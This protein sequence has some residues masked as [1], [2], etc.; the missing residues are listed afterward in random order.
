MTQTD[1]PQL[2]PPQITYFN[3]V[4]HSLGNDPNVTVLNLIEFPQGAGYLISIIVDNRKKARAL[5]TILD[6]QK[7]IGNIVINLIVIYDK[8]I[9][10]PHSRSFTA[11]G[12]VDLFEDALGTNR[13]FKFAEAKP[14]SPGVT[15]VYPVFTKSVIQFFN[16][17]ISDIYGNFNEVTAF[18][19]R[20]VVREEINGILINPS[21]EMDPSTEDQESK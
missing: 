10:R 20:D 1:L 8:T 13:F 9:V 18:V 6:Q 3:E 14:F 16:D 19:F 12:I 7:E 11:E 5:A 17:D 21:T 4:K 15:S 2:S